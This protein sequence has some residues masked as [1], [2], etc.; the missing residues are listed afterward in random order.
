MGGRGGSR[1]AHF[2]QCLRFHFFPSP[3]THFFLLWLSGMDRIKREKTRFLFI[4][5]RNNEN[6]RLYTIADRRAEWG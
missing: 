4:Y 5:F 1:R 2:I 3:L 6:F